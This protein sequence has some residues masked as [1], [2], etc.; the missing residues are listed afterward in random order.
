VT[1]P[2]KKSL[3][4]QAFSYS[5]SLGVLRLLASMQRF[6]SARRLQIMIDLLGINTGL[7]LADTFIV[8]QNRFFC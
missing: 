8:K 3:D 7:A 4:F 5:L 2:N 1:S 6:E